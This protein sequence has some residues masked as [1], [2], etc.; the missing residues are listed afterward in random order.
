MKTALFLICLA[1]LPL[2]AQDN[3]EL[4]QLTVGPR[5]ASPGIHL[6]AKSLDQ[7]AGVV[8][9][10]GSVEIGHDGADTPRHTNSGTVHTSGD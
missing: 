8:Y 5:G 4:K 9:L 6:A 3:S 7:S 2:A 10:K 1:L